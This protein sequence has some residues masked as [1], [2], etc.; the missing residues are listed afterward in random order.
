[1]ANQFGPVQGYDIE[2]KYVKTNA[3][4]SEEVGKLDLSKGPLEIKLSVPGIATTS[5][6]LDEATGIAKGAIENNGSVGAF[7]ASVDAD[8]DPSVAG[9]FL[10]HWE[11][12]FEATPGMGAT[13]VTGTISA[14]RPTPAP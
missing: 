10:L 3:D 4:G 14:V 2:L 13:G 8:G 6:T 9:E 1:M 12:D 11:A 5:L 7:T